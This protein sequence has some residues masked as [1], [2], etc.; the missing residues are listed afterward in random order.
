MC[1]CV[2]ALSSLSPDLATLPEMLLIRRRRCVGRR[3]RKLDEICSRIRGWQRHKHKRR[4]KRC[5]Q[6]CFFAQSRIIHS[7]VCA[8]GRVEASAAQSSNERRS[9]SARSQRHDNL[10]QFPDARRACSR[11]RTYRPTRERA[12]DSRL[13][14]RPAGRQAAEQASAY[15]SRARASISWPQLA[16]EQVH[17][18]ASA[19]I[20]LARIVINAN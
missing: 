16:A 15:N 4:H 2:R 5:K 11:Q 7:F 8:S 19:V 13:A 17:K 6:V 10:L 20:A 14:S 1:A 3:A 12:S 9:L 18:Q